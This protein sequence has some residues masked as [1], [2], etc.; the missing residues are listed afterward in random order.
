MIPKGVAPDGDE[1]AEA[2]ALETVAAQSGGIMVFLMDIWHAI[3]AIATTSDIITLVL[4]AVVA[5]GAG[6]MMQSMGSIVATTLIALVAFALAGY[7]R[8]VTMGGQNAAA[9]AIKDWQAFQDLHMLTLLAYALTFAVLIAAAH[10]ARSL[11]MRG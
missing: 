1:S 9:F 11:I 5:I 3:Q 6:F 8:A 10:A 4:I 7:V 2:A